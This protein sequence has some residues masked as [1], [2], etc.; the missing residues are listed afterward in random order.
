MLLPVKVNILR[1]LLHRSTAA[2]KS[3]SLACAAVKSSRGVLQKKASG[4]CS[5][6]TPVQ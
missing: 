3:V 6:L 4:T 5:P 2:G 1:L